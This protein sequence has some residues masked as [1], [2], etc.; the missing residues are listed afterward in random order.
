MEEIWTEIDSQLNA[1]KGPIEGMNASYSFDLSGEDGGMYGLKFSDG[2]AETFRSDPG[3]V[4]CALK[5][6]VADFKK[7]LSR[8]LE[9][10]GRFHDGEAESE[11][12][13]RARAET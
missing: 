2:E 7:L 8:Q 6:S 3:D 9:F 5:M 13:Y 12:Q 11:R 1:N 4:D 10:H